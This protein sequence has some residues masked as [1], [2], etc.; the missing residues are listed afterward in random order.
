MDNKPR[1]IQGGMGAS[2][3]NWELARAVSL[4]GQMGVVSGTALASVFAR[5]LQAG[6]EGGHVRRAVKAFP[7]PK[8]ANKVM[9]KYYNEGGLAEDGVYKRHP[10][11]TINSSPEL[12][13]LTVVGSFVEVWLAKEGH[14]GLVGINV[15]EKI[16]LP[17]L[18]TLYGAMLADVDFVIIGAGIPLHIPG[19]LDLMAN[20][21][22]ASI[23][24]SV[25]G[26]E[27]GDDF[28]I[29]FDPKE[30]GFDG[31]PPLK[32]P[33]FYA[34]ISSNVLAT[35]M[36][37]RA[38]GRVD[39]F[40]VETPTA[41]GHNAPPRG[42]LQLNEIGEPIYGEK[43]VVDLEKL[44]QA[45]LPFWMAGSYGTHEQLQSAL[46]NGAEGIQVGTAFAFCDDSGMA[47][48]DRLKVVHL[49]RQGE[50]KVFTDPKASP[51]GFPFKVATLDNSLYNDEV[52]Q[53]RDRICDLGFL[54]AAY[55]KENGKLGYR[56]ASEPEEIFVKKG[57]KMEDTVGRKCLCNAL[58]SAAGFPQM[59][60][61]GRLEPTLVTSGDEVVNI[62]QFIQEGNET[63]S[64]QDVISCLLGEKLVTS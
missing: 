11:Y 25:I 23:P 44:A 9:E 61:S 21:E 53:Q 30:T 7:S 2:I 34:I 55:K 33:L 29:H 49:A 41:G 57:G 12:L 48:V 6:D 45:G 13:Q 22:A 4:A 1:I 8:I 62:P 5:R 43:D 54:R 56:C 19:A 28:R 37:K 3:S 36:I 39:G 18:A 59:T 10:M 40:I 63:Y 47:E 16:Q 17:N 15:L 50:I 60:K 32:R 38:T 64:A 27:R 51:T 14:D 20:H 58:C 26:A 24:F 52:Y 42:P 35:A 46:D 31:L